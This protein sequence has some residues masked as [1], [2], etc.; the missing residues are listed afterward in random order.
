MM[1]MLT[2]PAMEE[3]RRWMHRNARPL[4]LA[5]WSQRKEGGSRDAVLG[6][7]ALYQNEDGGFG[8]ALE[9]DS[10]NPDSTPYTTR[11]ALTVLQDLGCA[12]VDRPMVQRALGF[13]TQTEHASDLGWYFN[14]PT[15]NDHPHAPWWSWQ[16]QSD[17]V[18]SVGLTAELAAHVLRIAPPSSPA[19]GMALGFADR[20][21]DRFL[22]AEK[23]GDMGLGGYCALLEV[24][25]ELGLATRWDCPTLETHLRALVNA[26]IVRDHAQWLHYG[27]RPSNYIKNPNSLWLAGNEDI[28]QTELDYLI[29]TRPVGAVWGIPWSWFDLNERYAKAF[30]ISENWWRGI[31]ALEAVELLS[32]FGRVEG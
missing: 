14:I 23:F 24:V 7:L 8:N 6:E 2:A 20:L 10:W 11:Y 13:L 17:E 32:K 15:N 30:A 16:G 4:E 3:I 19:Y 5:L 29:D 22:T 1:K 9:P 25:L 12:Q 28:L 31:K 26:S 18:E 21:F 27:V